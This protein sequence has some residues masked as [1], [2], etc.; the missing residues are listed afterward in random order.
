MEF[1]NRC[2]AKREKIKPIMVELED[3]GFA[4]EVLPPLLSHRLKLIQNEQAKDKKMYGFLVVAMCLSEKGQR[5]IDH[6]DYEEI[7]AG[8]DLLSENDFG[9]LFRKCQD[10]SK[11]QMQ[12]VEDAQ[13]N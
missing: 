2:Q 3:L 1:L 13:K 6:L 9:K 8:L 12:D 7:A 4:V 10:I 11:V 5:Q